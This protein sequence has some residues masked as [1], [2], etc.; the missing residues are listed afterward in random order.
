M[1]ILETAPKIIYYE[2]CKAN[3]YAA[4]RRQCTATPAPNSL[5]LLRFQHYYN[6]VIMPEIESL[7]VDFHYSYD[8]WYNH[9]TKQQQDSMD[10][11]SPDQLT[12][13]YVNMFCKS[14]KQL[15]DGAEL[16]K[17]R[18]ISAM[19]EE[20]KYVMGPVVYALEQYFKGF[21][22]YG[23]GKTWDQ[24]GK[25]YDDWHT[26][27]FTK[28]IQSDISGMDRSVTQEIK[29]IIAHP[30][31]KLVEPF[32]THV[33]TEAWTVHAYATHTQI[34]ANYFVD[35]TMETLGVG[36][37]YGE[38][39]SGSSDTT[40]FNTLVTACFQRYVMEVELQINID[41][42]DLTAKGDDSV[43]ACSP[44]IPNSDI[45]SAFNNVY[46]Q[47][48]DVKG[49]HTPYMTQHGCGMVLKF[50]S[51]SEDLSDIDYCS[52]NCYRCDS[53]GFRLTRR[54]D[55]FFYLTPWSDSVKN[56]KMKERLAYMQNLYEANNHWMRNLPILSP[57]N[58]HLQTKVRSDYTMVGKSRKQRTLSA[59][60]S[61]WYAKMFDSVYEKRLFEMQQKFGKNIA[62]SMVSQVSP[63]KTC[64]VKAYRAWLF[65]KLSI[66]EYDC[67]IIEQELRQHD[68]GKIVSPLL[69]YGLEMYNKYKDTLIHN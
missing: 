40:F 41:D 61:Q 11:L 19:C 38:V 50:L 3:L 55:R 29:N 16:P 59:K 63:T 1:P 22:G 45:R 20:H 58:N 28:V 54:I 69:E 35:K 10:S 36:T 7:L 15:C 6:T 23:G 18:A 43:I 62:Y 60:D 34:R 44:A 37:M 13:R 21:K 5:F 56:L 49:L 53:C 51:I 67:D 8:V 12:T 14:E 52:T 26:R 25:L 4:L 66:S 42:Y 65:T 2:N 9:L 30:L 68:N 32:V 17:N 39:F 48:A 33:D 57:F 27:G 24:T 31:Y 64:C 47:G 46:Y